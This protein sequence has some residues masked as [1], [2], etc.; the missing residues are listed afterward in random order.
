MRTAGT[1]EEINMSG[2][3]AFVALAAG[4]ALMVLGAFSA[5]AS[6]RDRGEGRNPGGSVQPCSLDGVNP[7]HHPEIFGNSATALSF[8]FVQGPDRTWHVKS[9]CSR[10][11]IY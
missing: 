5:A 2:R 8:G 11:S 9:N 7:A 10:S 4:T 3:Q 1:K 6:D